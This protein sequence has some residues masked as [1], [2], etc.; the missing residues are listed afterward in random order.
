MDFIIIISLFILLDKKDRS[1]R[2]RKTAGV[3]AEIHPKTAQGA[4]S[5]PD[6]RG[7]AWENTQQCPN[8]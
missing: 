5:L 7:S 2:D 6:T 3:Q 8:R 1:H 4:D